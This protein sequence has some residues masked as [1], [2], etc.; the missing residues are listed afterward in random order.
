MTTDQTS[1]ATPTGQA[2]PRTYPRDV[3]RLGAAGV[4]GAALFGAVCVAMHY[5]QP[6]LAPHE[7]FMSEYALGAGGWL[8]KTAF[9]ALGTAVACLAV[10]LRRSVRHGRAVR[11]AARL[12]LAAA[13]GFAAS[14]VFDTDPIEVLVTGGDP[15]WHSMLHDLAGFVAF[16]ATIVAALLLGRAFTHDESWRPLAP[17]ALL[18]GVALLALL[19]VMLASPVSAVG[20][21]Q[22]GFVVVLLLWFGV[23]GCWLTRRAD[24]DVPPAPDG[25]PSTRSLATLVVAGPVLFG[26][27]ATVLAFVEDDLSPS[28]SW[29]SDYALGSG[30]LALTAGFL[31]IAGSQA[32]LAVGLH[33]TLQPSRRRTFVVWAIGLIAVT[34]LLSGL[35]PSLLW[36]DPVTGDPA[37]HQVVH[38]TAGTVGFPFVVAVQLVLRGAYR[39]DPRWRPFAGVQLLYAVAFLVL[40]AV[41]MGS[42]STETGTAQRAHQAV[43]FT[44]FAVSGL[45]LWSLAGGPAGAGSEPRRGFRSA[46]GA[47]A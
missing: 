38:E 12:L 31:A 42:P 28:R 40:L 18:F 10:G 41:F 26:T 4:T 25:T 33:R 29:V 22:R 5:V 11:W 14:G 34:A 2:A 47:R 23:L 46:R 9:V 6:G 16:L 44:W 32:A 13:V 19:A 30:G 1:A 36:T 24:A 37:W 15:S 21:A 35:F 45:Y 20:V 3:R 17:V 7:H 27:A 39:R 8:M 43:M